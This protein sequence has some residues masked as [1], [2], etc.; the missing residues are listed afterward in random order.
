MVLA[1]V[2]IASAAMISCA[3]EE[4]KANEEKEVVVAK[5]CNHECATCP[6]VNECPDADLTLDPTQLL[7]AGAEYVNSAMDEAQAAVNA[8]AALAGS[9]WSDAEDKAEAMYDAA[10]AKAEA[11]YEAAEAKAEAILSQFDLD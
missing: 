8:A 11:M 10:E 2:A 9:A 5:A 1:V 4:K 6:N 3:G 7:N